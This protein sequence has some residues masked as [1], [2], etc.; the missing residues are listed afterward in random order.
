MQEVANEAELTDP[1]SELC[2]RVSPAGRYRCKDEA[3]CLEQQ[4]RTRLRALVLQGLKYKWNHI[5]A[6]LNKVHYDF[7]TVTVS[8]LIPQAWLL[9]LRNQLILCWCS[10]CMRERSWERLTR[11][12]VA[13]TE[14][15]GVLHVCFYFQMPF[16]CSEDLIGLLLFTY[17]YMLLRSV[18]VC[19]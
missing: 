8:F 15:G 2:A 18:C 12:Q 7:V 17:V 9:R 11:L 16:H 6:P 3:A 14:D 5:S 19:V 13:W 4:P 1:P 10:C